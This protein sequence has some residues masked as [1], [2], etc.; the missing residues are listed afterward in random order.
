MGLIGTVQTPCSLLEVIQQD[1]CQS[2]NCYSQQRS[3]ES[4]CLLDEDTFTLAQRT[5]LAA[6]SQQILRV[7]L[8]SRSLC[9]WAIHI[10]L[11]DVQGTLGQHLQFVSVGLSNQCLPCSD[12]R[13]P[14]FLQERQPLN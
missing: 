3:Y 11:A 1:G 4:S 6:Q 10:P 14:K 8:Q 13:L 9:V 12:S 5:A 7:L 2:R